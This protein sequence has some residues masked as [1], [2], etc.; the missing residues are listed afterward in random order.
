MKLQRMLV[1][2]LMV[3][4]LILSMSS[5]ALQSQASESKPVTKVGFMCVGALSDLGWNC[6]H[7]QGRLYLEKQSHGSIK[8]IVAEN[9]PE[10]AEAERVLEKLI[11]QGNKIIF[12]TA[13]G[14]MESTAKVARRHADVVFMQMSRFEKLPNLG[15]YQQVQYQPLYVAGIVAGR[16][17]KSN[18]LG[19]IAS[20]PIP[21]L[22]QEINAFTLGARS[23][24]PKAQ[25]YVVWI[26]KW[27]DLPVESEAVKSLGEQGIDV[28]ANGQDNQTAILKTCQDQGIY[29]VGLYMDGRQ[30]ASSK[31]LT[32]AGLDWGPFYASVVDSI[33]SHTWKPVMLNP[34][35]KSGCA[36]V[37]SFGD[38]VPKKV[39]AEAQ[40][41]EEQLKQG[42]LIVFKGPMNDHEG[43]KRLESGQ[44]ANPDQ[45]S[46]MDW[47][48]PG[49]NGSL[50]KR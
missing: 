3:G 46:Q 27:S 25:T 1:W 10:N 47:F 12:C 9:I 34:D 49:V 48:V 2:S 26:N 6:A 40:D 37:L 44:A 20:H 17:T 5:L 42:K 41:K 31:W 23:V 14:Y 19:F 28:I 35:I 45:L 38:A 21:N 33:N 50:P 36:K 7:E 4:L 11:A 24:N 30:L 18:K 29:C 39:R 15:C 32:G 43:K 8:T 13:Y 22:M 16:M